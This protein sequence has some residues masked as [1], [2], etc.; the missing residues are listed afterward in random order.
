MS[1]EKQWCPLKRL[2]EH[3]NKEFDVIEYSETFDTFVASIMDCPHCGK[4]NDIWVT[5]CKDFAAIDDR[6]NLILDLQPKL[7]KVTG[8]S[9]QHLKRAQEAESKLKL[10]EESIMWLKAENILL[11]K[12]ASDSPEFYSPQVIAGA[13][14]VR[15]RILKAINQ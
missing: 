5:Y 7:R 2:C 6:D 14:A 1:E 10:A 12:L 4:R 9:I 8:E 11:A 13:K 15:D 3:C